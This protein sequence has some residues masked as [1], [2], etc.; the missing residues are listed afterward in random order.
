MPKNRN[1]F[2]STTNATGSKKVNYTMPISK[3]LLDILACPAC[4]ADLDYANETLTCVKC[5]RT[6]PIIDDIPHLLVEDE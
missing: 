6:Y 2:D 1:L 3:E 5:K 4:K